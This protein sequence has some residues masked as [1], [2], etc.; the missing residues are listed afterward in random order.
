[1]AT[2]ETPG[3]AELKR[4]LDEIIRRHLTALD[5]GALGDDD[6][7]QALGL[8][9][10]RF[11]NLLADLDRDLGVEI[12]DGELSFENFR[13]PGAVHSTVLRLLGAAASTP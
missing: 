3:G 13:T 12:P 6:E 10:L 2:P 5:G 7:L 11:I 1:M 9:S 4:T 8:D